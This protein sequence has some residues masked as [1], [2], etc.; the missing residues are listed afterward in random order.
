MSD[1]VLPV[2]VQPMRWGES[3]VDDG[4]FVLPT[5]TVT[6]LLADVE[7]STSGW[8]AD[9]EA[10]ASAIIRLNELVDEQV[11][12]HDG[13]RPVEQ[14]EGDS[15][16][17]A[18]ARARDAI[19][20]ALAIQ[21]ALAGER[22]SIRM[23]VHTG[24]V[25]RRDD[26]NY[27]G[28]AVNRT[29]RLRN[30]AHGGQT[31]LSGVTRDLVADALPDGV[32][33]RDL[34][35]HRLRDL[36]R[37]ERVFQ[38]C[39]RE[40]RDEFPALR[41]LDVVPHNLPSLRTSF[42]GR[43]EE[44]GAI[45]GLLSDTAFLTLTGAGGCG[46]TRL[47]LQVGAEVLDR[48]PDGVWLVE[49]ASVVDPAAVATVVA[50]V[51][52]V[53]AAPGMAAVDVVIDHLHD[54]AMLLVLD[55][56][57]HVLDAAAVV[58]DA[59]LSRC[60]S[61]QVLATSRQ[62][63]GVD[64]EVAWRVPSLSLP[65][66]SGPAGISAVNGSEAVRLF[67][68]RARRARAG[69]EV[70]EQ[71][72][73]AVAGICRRLDG[74]PL[75]VELAAARVRVLTPA[76][77]ADGLSERFRMLTG[78][79]RTATPRQ[80]TLE[81]SVDWSH[82]L[83]TDPEQVVF[84]RLAVFAGGFDLEAAEDVCA[85]A[86]VA[87][88]QVLDLLTLLIDKSLVL[89]HDDDERSR[90]QLLETIRAYAERRLVSAGDHMAA[91]NRHRGYYL[92]LAEAAEPHL[93]SGG[94]A[95]WSALIS[96][97]YPN[98][99]GALAWSEESG[100]VAE[101]ARMAAALHLFWETHGPIADGER[102]LD[103][104]ITHSDK[105]DAG[106][107]GRLHFARSYVAIVAFDMGTGVKHADEGLRIALEI[108]DDRLAGRCQVSLGGARP[109]LGEDPWPALDDGVARAR[110]TGDEF[111]LAEGLQICGVAA[112]FSNPDGAR[113]YLEESLAVARRAGNHITANM[114]LT[115]LG[116]I[117]A[118]QGEL[119][120]AER[121]LT[122][123]VEGSAVVMYGMQASTALWELAS[124]SVIRGDMAHALDLIARVDSVIRQ[125]GS[126]MVKYAISW[127]RGLAAFAEGR[128]ED[129]VRHHRQAADEAGILRGWALPALIEAELALGD[130]DAAARDTDELAQLSEIY[131]SR[132]GS[133]LAHTLRAR[134]D[135]RQGRVSQ[136]EEAAHQA[137]RVAKDNS[138]KTVAV[139]A[140]EALA[141]CAADV[142]SWQEAARLMG[143]AHSIRTQS[144]YARCVSERDHDVV[145][146][147][148]ALGEQSFPEHFS[149]GCALTL[150][151]AVS[152]AERGRGSRKRPTHGWDSITPTE[153]QVIDLV[154]G[155]LTNAQIA[156]R[157][158]MS[159]RTV[160]TH[161]TH[162]F[163]K[164]NIATRTELAAETAGRDVASDSRT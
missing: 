97:E 146:I 120:E 91:R 135:R 23:G 13:V 11:G 142:Q 78:G 117:S 159:P 33:L 35:T 34:G 53:K 83:L 92:R 109:F 121:L 17:A 87:S 49:L 157:L 138:L 2:L 108:S 127:G 22:L 160:Q 14:G 69:F 15:F 90:Y 16:V 153:K 80:Q 7:G 37:P 30:L 106:L 150:D 130:L 147:Q 116:T 163:A 85:D 57:E 123:A 59:V 36:S 74:I 110:R 118:S 93:E 158:F 113:P 107:V 133:A 48:Y 98:L 18:F 29:A 4:E 42:V 62:A 63:L 58:A 56:C 21:Q 122:E 105:L 66:D 25:Q 156:E 45:S 114:T 75:A 155:G 26:G 46:K 8:E 19:G 100:D 38:L 64:G 12:V 124:V 89:V 86:L 52:S 162:V 82:D 151:E 10:M 144:G 126:P 61:V 119:A 134:V 9:A 136:A 161:L 141:G 60:P 154:R 40:L 102:W 129:A 149:A 152:Y 50:D 70:T 94:Q 77:I 1:N 51:L 79:S 137:L 139:D 96:T 43:V 73:D 55:N 39:H 47:A 71:N 88:H 65:P 6:L 101:L 32:V 3:P 125:T 28:L 41:S 140:L 72:C 24:D 99:L 81:A 84:R 44:L 20:C 111:A 128:L 68:D 67:S 115:T 143:A 131:Q 112:M 27:V 95:E 54:K 5:G 148:D 132:W 164:L 76:Q 103:A 31:V 145:S 104:A